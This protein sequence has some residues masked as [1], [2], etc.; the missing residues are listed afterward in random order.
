LKASSIS[1]SEVVNE[2]MTGMSFQ[3]QPRGSGGTWG[4][5][6]LAVVKALIC[7]SILLPV[8]IASLMAS[9]TQAPSGVI[10][11]IAAS[12]AAPC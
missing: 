5:L 9:S 2:S 7:S 12:A 11:P 4:M 10:A 3:P 6:P 1:W 8:S